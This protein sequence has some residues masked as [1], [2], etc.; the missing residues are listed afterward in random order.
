VVETDAAMF[1]GFR[2]DHEDGLFDSSAPLALF[3]R[4][5]CGLGCFIGEGLLFCHEISPVISFIH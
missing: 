4:L 3:T 5:R 1:R 2:I